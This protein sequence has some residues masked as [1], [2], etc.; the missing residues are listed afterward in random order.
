MTTKTIKICDG[1]DDELE[2]ISG[3]TG[4]WKHVTM[5]VAGLAG[6]PT[7]RPDEP[8]PTRYDLC[9]SCATRFLEG[10]RPKTWPRHIVE[11]APHAQL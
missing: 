5:S 4:D 10:I 3:R 11:A 8:E 6:Y 9:P 2:V 7:C 1:C